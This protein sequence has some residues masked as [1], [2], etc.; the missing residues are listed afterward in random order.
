MFELFKGDMILRKSAIKSTLN[1]K[2]EREKK[3]F[4]SDLNTLNT[5]KEWEFNILFT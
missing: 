4:K 1:S 2:S 3:S 5:L